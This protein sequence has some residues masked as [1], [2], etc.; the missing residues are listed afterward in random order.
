MN[1]QPWA[2]QLDWSSRHFEEGDP[3]CTCMLCGEVIGTADDDPRRDSHDEDCV[4]CA[5]CE[6]AVRLWK[7]Q[8]KDCKEQRYHTACFEKILAPNPTRGPVEHV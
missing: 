6:I 5:V 4:G 2:L 3:R 7:G 1:I 8:G